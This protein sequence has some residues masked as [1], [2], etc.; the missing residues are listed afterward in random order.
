MRELIRPWGIGNAIARIEQCTNSM[1]VVV[2]GGY[3]LI[4]CREGDVC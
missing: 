3:R 1:M 2:A 4:I